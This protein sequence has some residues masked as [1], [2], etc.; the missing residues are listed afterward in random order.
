MKYEDRYHPS[1]QLVFKSLE[2]GEIEIT[3]NHLVSVRERQFAHNHRA[4]LHYHNT[5]EVNV[6]RGVSG[7]L[8][9]EG[10]HI[11]LEDISVL[12]T[13]PGVLHSFDFSPGEGTF[14][15]LHISISKLRQYLNLERF[16][17][18]DLSELRKI[19][20][21]D[22]AYLSIVPLVD[23]M[24]DVDEQ[25]VFTQIRIILEILG[26]V[27]QRSEGDVYSQKPSPVLKKVIDYTEKNYMN[28]I[29]LDMI[30]SYVG[31]S[32]SY[33]SRFFKKATGT[34]YF[35]YLTLMRLERAKEKIYSGESVSD[36]CYA[37]GFDNISYFIQLFKKH[38]DG[39]S[40]GK[41]REKQ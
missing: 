11:N 4:H 2:E 1:D 36:S 34:G 9:I 7:S 27:L 20:Y 12:V 22:P 21:R 3:A 37:C 13:P 40:P 35:T 24:K 28:K 41:I 23:S 10:E 14:D 32:R 38:N 15:V 30:S 29:S 39:I 18:K 5:I 17:G 25:D 33:F 19:N 8:W 31:L 16:C 6:N 26:T